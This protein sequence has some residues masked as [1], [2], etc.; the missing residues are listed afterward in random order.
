MSLAKIPSLLTGPMNVEIVVHLAGGRSVRIALHARDVS[1]RQQ[2]T[3][4]AVEVWGIA[5]PDTAPLTWVVR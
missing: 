1:I 3:D 5:L 2:L 4:L